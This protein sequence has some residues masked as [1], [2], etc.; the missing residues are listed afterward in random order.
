MVELLCEALRR[1]VG[2]ENSRNHFYFPQV[3]WDDV[4]AA[5][6]PQRVHP[7][8]FKYD[9]KFKHQD[10]AIEPINE[11]CVRHSHSDSTDHLGIS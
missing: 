7:R 2:Q 3:E 8:G 11:I 5:V 4:I 1:C 6:V 9:T 10:M